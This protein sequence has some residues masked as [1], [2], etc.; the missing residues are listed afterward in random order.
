MLNR[1]KR[2]RH[3]GGETNRRILKFQVTEELL[4]FFAAK[5]VS[6]STRNKARLKI[7]SQ[8]YGLSTSEI[9]PYCKF[10]A[11]NNLYSSGAFSYSRSELPTGSV[12]GRYCSIGPNLEILGRNHPLERFS[13]S[14]FTYHRHIFDTAIKDLGGSF[15]AV[16]RA[17][18]ARM[19]RLMNDVWIGQRVMLARGVTIGNGAVVA[20]G[21]VVT[22]D[23]PPYEVWGGVPAKLIRPRFPEKIVERLLRL[24]W[25]RYAF[26]EFEGVKIDGPIEDA[27]T[28]LEDVIAGGRIKA[29]EPTP[30]LLS[31]IV[32][33]MTA[34]REDEPDD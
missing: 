28:G 31:E 23:I 22:K 33:A 15:M 20:A 9:E 32:G 16:K 18:S 24:E 25:W 11:G 27:L 10:G 21:A 2:D 6:F 8:L 30:I 7:G 4:E 19:P 29:F 17:P 3:S 1:L 14:P 5:R 34:A 26:P 13:T 12:I